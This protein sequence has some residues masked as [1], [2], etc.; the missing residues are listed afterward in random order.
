MAPLPAL[1]LVTALLASPVTGDDAPD[2]T[3]T[4]LVLLSSGSPVALDSERAAQLVAEL[5][6]YLDS[7]LTSVAVVGE[8]PSQ[9]ELERLWSEKSS[10]PHALLQATGRPDSA[11]THL[12]G[13]RF[14]AFFGFESESGPSPV[15]TRDEHRHLTSYTKCPGLDGLLLSCNVQSIVP[16]M[17]SSADCDRWKAI[18]R[19]QREAG[20]DRGGV[21]RASANPSLRRKPPGYSH[22]D[23]LR[24]PARQFTATDR[25]GRWRR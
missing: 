19:E 15:L 20:T 21:G 16:G 10:Q 6:A 11:H 14:T 24:G 25:S 2:P 9:D 23:R 8:Q 12:R 1:F 4:T 22:T 17:S 7:C 5:T 13:S 3:T 18:E